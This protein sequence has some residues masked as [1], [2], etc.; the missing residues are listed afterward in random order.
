MWRYGI[1]AFV[2]AVMLAM[3]AEAALI[4]T[5]MTAVAALALMLAGAR[6][7]TDRSPHHA[8]NRS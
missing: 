8:I 1:A 7:S 2:V 6:Q 4:G 3:V 5:A